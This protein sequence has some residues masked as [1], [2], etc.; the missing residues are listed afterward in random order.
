M[1]KRVVDH[2][3]GGY[4]LVD[5]DEE[6]PKLQK[7]VAILTSIVTLYIAQK[8]HGPNFT[9][10]QAAEYVSLVADTFPEDLQ[11]TVL[12]ALCEWGVEVF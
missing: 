3:R 1:T 5:T 12:E 10:D 2:P 8:V 9:E 4:F 11:P 7:A 6:Y